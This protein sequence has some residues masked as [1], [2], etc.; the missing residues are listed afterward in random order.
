[1]EGKTDLAT[2]NPALAAEW[3]AQRNSP[4]TVHEVST[5]SGK[6]VWWCCANGHEWQAVVQDR[7]NGS[8]CPICSGKRV[9]PGFDG[10]L[11]KKTEIRESLAELQ[12]P[13]GGADIRASN[14]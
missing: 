10:R 3:V 2:L 9:L 8:G 13:L 7:S 4:L 6:K 12:S 14:L 5:H 1:M 11:E